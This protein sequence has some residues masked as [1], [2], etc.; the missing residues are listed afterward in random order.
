[1]Y[2]FTT[3]LTDI[4]FRSADRWWAWWAIQPVKAVA[5]APRNNRC[6]G[7]AA[8]WARSRI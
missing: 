3:T 4:S 1:M 8:V 2:G 5:D 6:D 7:F